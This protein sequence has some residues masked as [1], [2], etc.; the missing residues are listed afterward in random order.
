MMSTNQ[1]D[2]EHRTETEGLLHKPVSDLSSKSFLIAMALSSTLLLSAAALFY[3]SNNISSMS[4]LFGGN[5]GTFHEKLCPAGS[6]VTTIYASAAN[7]VDSAGI[8]CSR[9]DDSGR[10]GGNGGDKRSKTCDSGFREVRYGFGK[11]VGTLE[12]ACAYDN[13]FQ[14]LSRDNL[15]AIDSQSKG[16]TG[17]TVCPNGQVVTGMKI[18]S[19]GL[20]DN[21]EFV[22]G[23]KKY[24]LFIMQV[25]FTYT[26]I[27][28][29]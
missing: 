21:L 14:W 3:R 1:H 27:C 10:H 17:S 5:G 8:I 6:Y 7:S 19:G 29:T 18:R 13:N 25:Y 11:F 20:V 15:N 23:G 12:A 4:E 22:C 16:S 26:S 28:A 24:A 9:G 2:V